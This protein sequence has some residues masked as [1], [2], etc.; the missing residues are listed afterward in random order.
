MFESSAIVNEA[1]RD[2]CHTSYCDFSWQA[3]HLAMVER[4][5][6]TQHLAMLGCHLSWQAQHYGDVGARNDKLFHTKCVAEVKKSSVL[7]FHGRMRSNHVRIV[8]HCKSH[9][10]RFVS[11]IVMRLFL[12]GLF[13]WQAQHLGMF[14][15]HF[16]WRAQYLGMFKGDSCCS[17]YCTG[18]FMCCV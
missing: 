4:R 2:L 14:E 10:M 5:F 12:A 17:A 8:R 9:F 11:Q 6:Y 13:S 15:C 18:R 7:Q 16:P 1:S 3:Q